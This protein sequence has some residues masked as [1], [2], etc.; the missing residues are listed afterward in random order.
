[1]AKLIQISGGP[2]TGKTTSL[3]KFNEKE[4]FIIDCDKKG[5]SWAGWKKKYNSENKN[6]IATSDIQTIYKIL[7]MVSDSRPEIKYIAI[8]TISG[9]MS[10]AWMLERRKPT[11]DMWRQYA[12]DIYELYDMIRSDLR[13]DLMVFAMAH[14][15]PYDDNGTTKWRTRFEGKLLTK[16]NMSGKLNY[17]LYT[18]VERENDTNQYYFVTQTDG[19]NEARSTKGVLPSVMEADLYEVA[20]LIREKDD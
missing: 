20:K 10:D 18:K 15:E 7:K 17:N 19:R 9:I 4:V 11:Q 6:Y 12:A 3:E 1:M 2:G 16:S 14:I 8:D 5:L 13:E